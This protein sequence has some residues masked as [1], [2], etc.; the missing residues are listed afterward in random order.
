MSNA[1]KIKT[2]RMAT[3]VVAVLLGV[4]AA[5]VPAGPAY[6]ATWSVVATPNAS[7]GLNVLTGVD[8]RGTTDVWAV[9]HADHS[10]A[11]PFQRPLALRWTGSSWTQVATPALA[12]G[13]T[14]RAVDG[15][16]SNNVWAVGMRS[17]PAGGGSVGAAPL[18]ERWNGSAWS[19]TS[20]PTPSNA[21]GAAL[22]GVKTFST[23]S[24]W[25]VGNYTASTAPHARTLI[26]RWD[27]TSWTVVPS[28]SP[29]PAVNL[30]S[31][32]DGASADDVW[33][34]GNVGNDGYGG[35]VAGVVLH[36]NGSAWSQATVPGT[37]S[38]GTLQV[39]TLQDVV[40]V[41]SN[42]VWIVGRAFHFGLFRMVPIFIHWNG[43]NW[44]RGFVPNAPAGGFDG[45]S[46]LSPTQVYAVG[47]VIARWNGSTWT[48]ENATIP[49]SLLDAAATGPG[50]VWAAGY[51]YD[52][53]LAQIRTLT[54]RTTNG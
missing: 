38:D 16:A 43:Q 44:Q 21:T 45:V 36:W 32:V 14:F 8:A 39:P 34:I 24:A 1:T 5:A 53:A 35:T 6:A 26:E 52:S 51:R 29:D 41:A 31:D 20:S 42:D 27:G 28:P 13:G 25:A 54:M 49:G 22:E 17:V 30:L 18:T 48:L 9:G 3:F 37:T 46:A 4:A 11:Q 23:A 15:S 50:T 47:S 7:A 19:V 12:A 10:P 33:A 40:A 2:F